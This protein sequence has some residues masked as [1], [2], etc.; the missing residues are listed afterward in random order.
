MFFA[1]D[2]NEN[3]LLISVNIS[4]SFWDI[5][6]INLNVFVFASCLIQKHPSASINPLKYAV[7][8]VGFMRLLFSPFIPFRRDTVRLLHPRVENIVNSFAISSS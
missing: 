1:S 8:N 4:F 3:K 5:S 2:P 7:S 6:N